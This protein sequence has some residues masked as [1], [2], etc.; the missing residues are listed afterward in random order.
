MFTIFCF[1]LCINHQLPLTGSLNHWRDVITLLAGNNIL[2]HSEKSED[3]LWDSGET[4]SW[5]CEVTVKMHARKHTDKQ[6]G[7]QFRAGVQANRRNPQIDTHVHTTEQQEWLHSPGSAFTHLCL[8]HVSFVPLLRWQCPVGELCEGQGW[9][10]LLMCFHKSGK[11]LYI[12]LLMG[13]QKN[14]DN[15]IRWPI[16]VPCETYVGKQHMLNK[17]SQSISQ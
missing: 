4:F 14:Q 1:I 11:C 10:K 16:N 7:R 9:G 2:T 8:P 6:D 17:I 3:M 12:T 13:G 5:Q 15:K